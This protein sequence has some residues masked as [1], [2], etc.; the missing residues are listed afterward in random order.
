[1]IERRVLLLASSHDAL[2]RSR[3]AARWQTAQN[4]KRHVGLGF[5]AIRAEFSL[6]RNAQPFSVNRRAG[7]V[8]VVD[9]QRRRNLMASV[10]GFKLSKDDRTGLAA[11]T[12]PAT[13][14][15]KWA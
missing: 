4:V 8:E 5:A 9:E 13:V 1:M 10:I 14:L 11:R 12:C 3:N 7:V 15:T 2:K 6:L